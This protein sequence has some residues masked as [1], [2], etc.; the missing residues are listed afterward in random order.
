MN[1]TT[2]LEIEVKIKSGIKTPILLEVSLAT[3]NMLSANFQMNVLFAKKPR[4]LMLIILMR[5]EKTMNSIILLF[6]VILAI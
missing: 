6:F 4:S 1:A 5:I 2:N 3:E